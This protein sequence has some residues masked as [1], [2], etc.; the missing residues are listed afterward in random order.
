MKL[1]ILE[2]KSQ[3]ADFDVVDGFIVRAETESAARM[4]AASQ[5]QGKKPE[6]W[7]LGERSTCTELTADGDS[8]VV[9]ADTHAG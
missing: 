7:M 1:W 3:R 6:T 4:W 9:I 8:G 5:A 2:R